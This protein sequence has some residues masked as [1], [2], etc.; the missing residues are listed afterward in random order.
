MAPSLG[1]PFPSPSRASIPSPEFFPFGETSSPSLP[2][3]MQ[4]QPSFHCSPPWNTIPEPQ[5]TN[6]SHGWSQFGP[7]DPIPSHPPVHQQYQHSSNYA[8]EFQYSQP[9]ENFSFTGTNDYMPAPTLPTYLPF[10]PYFNH[11]DNQS[12]EQQPGSYQHYGLN[13]IPY[14]TNHHYRDFGTLQ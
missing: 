1:P 2:L 14:E 3:L 10:L 9:A 5:I 6:G 8:A 12:L 13:Q 4:P 11:S 7:T